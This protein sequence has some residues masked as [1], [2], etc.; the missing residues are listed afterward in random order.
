MHE[1][2]SEPP[3]YS[4][5]EHLA[6]STRRLVGRYTYHDDIKRLVCHGDICSYSD[7]LKAVSLLYSYKTAP[8][9]SGEV[10]LISHWVGGWVKG[11]RSCVSRERG[12]YLQPFRQ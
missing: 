8:F 2:D 5:V 7:I 3:I 9:S 11:T 10:V 12:S 6:S 1:P 4:F